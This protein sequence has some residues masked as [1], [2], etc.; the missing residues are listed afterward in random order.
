MDISGHYL[1]PA[2]C[3]TVWTSL[4]DAQVLERC[5][6]GCER[7]EWLDDCTVEASLVLRVGTVRRR[8]KGRVRIADSRPWN[9]YTLLI[10]ETGRGTS[11]TS[12][13]RLEPAHGG[14]TVRYEVEAQLDGYLSRLGAAVAG[15]IAR[16]L[17]A[18]F[19][20]R[21]EAEMGDRERRAAEGG[22]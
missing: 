4:H 3:K 20:K 9:S 2:E 10:G 7:I 12:R 14:T 1:L 17:A 6:P 22:G 13:I 5:V 8:Y 11:V 16:R 15:A 21:L 18:A 19:F